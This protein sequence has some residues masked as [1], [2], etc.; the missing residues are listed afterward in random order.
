M[1]LCAKCTTCCVVLCDTHHADVEGVEQ[2]E[3]QG[4][5]QVYKEPGGDV[6][7][8]DGAGVVNHLTGGA[9]VGGS[10]VQHDIWQGHEHMLL[11]TP[12]L[13]RNNAL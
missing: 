11:N 4:G 5:D 2:V 10:K 13:L 8:A 9:H 3:G 6:V 1:F 12:L 7:D